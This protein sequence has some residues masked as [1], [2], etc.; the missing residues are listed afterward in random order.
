MKVLK[1]MV[2]NYFN[3]NR[4]AKDSWNALGYRTYMEYARKEI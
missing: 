2:L 3:S 4:I 1:L